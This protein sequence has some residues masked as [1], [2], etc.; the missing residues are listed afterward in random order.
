MGRGGG[1]KCSHLF[2]F[3]SLRAQNR[4]MRLLWLQPG[5]RTQPLVLIF[6]HCARARRTQDRKCNLAPG[7]LKSR[8][9]AARTKMRMAPLQA[10]KGEMD[11]ARAQSKSLRF[12]CT[13]TMKP[14][15]D[16]IFFR[17]PSPHA[18]HA[19]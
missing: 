7:G 13:R 4:K 3:L 15:A 17:K 5:G 1:K 14:G 8:G 18:L 19:R 6:L 10:K 16:R 12:C 11:V 2:S 9:L